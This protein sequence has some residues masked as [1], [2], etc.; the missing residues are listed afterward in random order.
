MS[1]QLKI[2]LVVTIAFISMSTITLITTL[3]IL[4]YAIDNN[5]K[6]YNNT[7]PYLDMTHPQF[8]K[9]PREIYA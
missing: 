4:N 1:E 9:I 8:E 6:L 7:I 5:E 2:L 3:S